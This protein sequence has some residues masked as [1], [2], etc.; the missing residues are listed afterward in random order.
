M[1]VLVIG[2]GG[3]EHALVK[4]IARSPLAG[5]VYCLPGNPGMEEAV[6]LPGDPMDIAQ[7]VRTALERR[8]GLCVVAP[9]DPLDQGLVDALEA[10]GVPCFGPTQAAARIE[11]SK[12]FA[13]ELMSKAG[14]PT[15]RYRVFDSLDEAAAY[16][17]TQPF[18][19]VVKADGLA[20]GKGVVVAESLAEAVGALED[21]LSGRAFG[22][23]G[24]RV[25]IE[26]ALTGPEVSLL[27]LTDGETVVPLL[28]AMD[29]KRAL[30]GDQGPNTGGMGAVAPSPLFG[31][32]ETRQAVEEIL[33]PAVRAMREAGCPFSGCLFAGL[34]LT[35]EGPRVL[36]F[37][38]RF[39]DPETQ[40]VLPLMESDLLGHLLACREGRLKDETVRFRPGSACCLVFASGGYPGPFETGLPVRVEPRGA[41]VC[42]AGVKEMDGQL[43]TAGGRVLSLTAVGET[44]AGAVAGAY[45]AADQQAFPGQH[46]RGDIGRKA[47][48]MKGEA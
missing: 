44:L 23:S 26:E 10:A 21:M 34:M 48:G 37:N 5:T 11:S 47:L 32:A 8:V 6:R 46:I 13:K 17:R 2:S 19:L 4:A 36:E 40:A 30:D 35:P 12:A 15:A 22:P 28:S 14:I 38:A 45:R 18:P 16:V 9:E 33:L 20:K 7:T 43:V 25:V 27:C 24:V 31:E 3:R 42:F 29:H 1:N 41:E 39:G